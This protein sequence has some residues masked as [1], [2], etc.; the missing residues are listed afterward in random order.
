MKLS[1]DRVCALLPGHTIPE[2]TTLSPDRIEQIV[3]LSKHR[4]F[5]Y[6]SAEIYHL[7]DPAGS[8]VE[9][10]TSAWDYGPLG[11]EK[12]ENVKRQWWKACV[13]GREDV[14]GMDSA[15]IV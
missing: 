9:V 1:A 14:V 8:G 15:V 5:G 2:L 12:R 7:A 4:G 10:F 3:G 13:Q 11:V 6:P